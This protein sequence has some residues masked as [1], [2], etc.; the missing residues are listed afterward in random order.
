MTQQP[1]VIYIYGLDGSGKTTICRELEEI[2]RKKG[3]QTVYRW[4]RFNHYASRAINA[5]GR[6]TGLAY[7]KTYSDGT[8]IG[9]HC[10]YKSSFLSTAYCLTTIL[11]TFFSTILKIWIPLLFN[12]KIIILDRF[13]CDTIIDL[14]IDTKNPNL[15]NQWKA[16]VLKKFL[17]HKTISIYL[18]VD[19]TAIVSR[20]PDMQWDENF[21]TRLK[22]YKKMYERYG[23]GYKVNNNGRIEAI[24]EEIIKIIEEYEKEKS[25]DTL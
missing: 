12:R 2:F 25:T 24:I 15:M 16:R 8:R 22:L 14:S 18:D 11:D 1:K 13:I 9:Y 7:H 5:I 19:K 4:M 23:V 20:R 6:L 3:V 17:P 10:Y 21:D